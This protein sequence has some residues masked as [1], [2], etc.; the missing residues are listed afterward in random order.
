MVLILLRIE[1]CEKNYCGHLEAW[2]RICY[3]RQKRIQ[4]VLN[5]FETSLND[6]TSTGVLRFGFNCP[7]PSFNS[8]SVSATENPFL[9][10]RFS[11]ARYNSIQSSKVQNDMKGSGRL[12]FLHMRSSEYLSDELLKGYTIT[13]AS[14]QKSSKRLISALFMI[15]I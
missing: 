6:W 14:L 10:G 15:E 3:V 11:V 8:L 2:F 9:S 12:S 7:H 4:A 13:K 1:L 5:Y